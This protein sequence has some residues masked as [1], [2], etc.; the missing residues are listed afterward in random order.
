MDGRLPYNPSFSCV[1]MLR[2]K[3]LLQRVYAIC[4][5]MSFPHNIYSMFQDVLSPERKQHIPRCPPL[6]MYIAY[7]RISSFQLVPKYPLPRM[8][9][10]C[11]RISSPQN[12]CSMFQNV[13]SS[14]C[15]QLVPECSRFRIYAAFSKSSLPRIYATYSKIFSP[16][17]YIVCSRISSFQ[18][19]CSMFQNILS[20]KC[21]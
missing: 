21:I 11:S 17:M 12:I 20:P 18:N 4:S 14:E 13:L 16:Q 19:M 8:Y 10:A 5:K 6:R 9:T 1:S 3:E 15:I 2:T 7:S